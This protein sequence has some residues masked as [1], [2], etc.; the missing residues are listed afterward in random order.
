MRKTIM[1]FGIS[2]FVGSN[3]FEELKDEY[4][5][6]GTYHRTPVDIKNVFTIACDVLKKDLVNTLIGLFRPDFTIYC[7]GLSSLV[8]CQLN[9]KFADALLTT[10]L[11]N[12]CTSSE[13]F[14]SKFIFISSGFVHGGENNLYQESDTPF[15]VS[16]YGSANASSE[17]YV[18]RSCLNY[19]IFRCCYLYGRSYNPIQ[20]NFFERMQKNFFIGKN[21]Q[22]DD[23]VKMG[24]LDVVILAKILKIAF[25]SNIS[26]RLFQV[27]SKDQMTLFDF[28]SKYAEIFGQDKNQIIRSAWSFPVSDN[29]K[30]VSENLSFKM[31]TTNLEDTFNLKVPTVVDSLKITHTRFKNNHEAKEV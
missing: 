27:S 12:V 31:D 23:K 4:R 8:E 20:L 3:L 17:F 29:A 9:P 25:K 15:P 6:I 28:S 11:I 26:N 22:A 18:Q 21:V 16:V 5:I 19:M 2:S 14:K 13:R 30:N 1:I 10:G 7:V 24:F